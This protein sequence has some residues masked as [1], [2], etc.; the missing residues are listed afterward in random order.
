MVSSINLNH[1]LTYSH[2]RS[3]SRT[4]THTHTRARA[5]KGGIES[6]QLRK[7]KEAQSIQPP[8]HTHTYTHRISAKKRE[9]KKTKAK[10]GPEEDEKIKALT[11]EIQNLKQEFEQEKASWVQVQSKRRISEIQKIGQAMLD[12]F[13]RLQCPILKQA[14]PAYTEDKVRLI[15]HPYSYTQIFTR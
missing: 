12:K 5:S 1:S 15:T 9:V 3:R 6:E 4:H 14:T 10:K 11:Q 7:G 8:T 2:T 13:V